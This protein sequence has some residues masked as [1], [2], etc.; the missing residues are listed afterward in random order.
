M[1]ADAYALHQWDTAILHYTRAIDL[2]QTDATLWTNRAASYLAK[3]WHAQ[4]LHDAEH[5]ASLRP[6]WFRPWAR[7]GAALVGLHKP[8]PALEAYK[9]ALKCAKNDTTVNETTVSGIQNALRD[10]EKKIQAAVSAEKK[11]SAVAAAPRKPIAAPVPSRISKLSGTKE[12]VNN[13]PQTPAHTK[14]IKA[15]LPSLFPTG[16]RSATSTQSHDRE[17]ME[18]SLLFSNAS[19][20]K[21]LDSP[22]NATPPPPSSVPSTQLKMFAEV[23]A[24]YSEVVKQVEMLRVLM[25]K[26]HDQMMLDAD[27]LQSQRHEEVVNIDTKISSDSSPSC[28]GTRSE[29]TEDKAIR[30]LGSGSEEEEDEDFNTPSSP[31]LKQKESAEITESNTINIENDGN[32][33]EQQKP[34]DQHQDLLIEQEIESSLENSSGSSS[35]SSS[36]NEFDVEN[37]WLDTVY[38]A[39]KQLLGAVET[40]DHGFVPPPPPPPPS[41]SSFA[42]LSSRRQPKSTAQPTEDAT[43]RRNTGT[44]ETT[45]DSNISTKDSNTSRLDLGS[46]QSLLVLAAARQSRKDPFGV[47]RYACKTCG[48]GKCAQY[49][50]KSKKMLDLQYI[51]KNYSQ[52]QHLPPSQQSMLQG[53]QCSQCGCDCTAHETEKEATSREIAQQQAKERQE[54]IKKQREERQQQRQRHHQPPPSPET[55]RIKR[56]VAAAARKAAAEDGGEP[57]QCTDCDILTQ[58]KRGTCISCKACSGFKIYY[59]STDANNPEIMLYCSLCGCSA[60]SHPVDSSWEQK[61]SAR[62]EAENAAAAR[63][64]A[65]AR[66]SFSAQ[67]TASASARKEEADAY[68]VLGLHYGADA[69]AVTRAYKRLALKLHPDKVSIARRNS[70]QREEDEG[71]EGVGGEAEAAA[72]AAF[73]KVTQAYKL[74]SNS[75]S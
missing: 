20:D 34:G 1:G 58:S 33:E 60:E 2:H 62:R 17:E 67:A 11:R 35:S 53:R 54:R 40:N 50:N 12:M 9:K 5:A 23:Q 36:D 37:E 30:D 45:I 41:S 8:E 64:A 65:R 49:D 27:N 43:S 19:L 32:D 63:A 61:E 44:T 22:T 74:L 31:I 10:A 52:Q 46:L 56:V 28:G 55:E 29:M 39:R 72:H 71:G 25:D 18:E 7:K 66:H 24:Q 16:G 4:A 70:G 15:E 73:V 21:S 48:P 47:E 51:Q 13:N 3:G 69:K 14:E 59:S 42:S 6:E 38:A 57:L 75:K 68:A 26:L